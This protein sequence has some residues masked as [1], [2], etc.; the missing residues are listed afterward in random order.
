MNATE[1]TKNT[2]ATTTM[3]DDNVAAYMAQLNEMEKQ[4]HDI[5][6]EHLESSFNLTKSN[7]YKEWLRNIQSSG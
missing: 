2:P 5:A 1:T 6:K 7:G 4:A 3:P